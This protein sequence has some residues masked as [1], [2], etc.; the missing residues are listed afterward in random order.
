VK[1]TRSIDTPAEPY[2]APCESTLTTFY[3]WKVES[4]INVING[5]G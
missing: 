3:A 1:R 5:K 2:N 4:L